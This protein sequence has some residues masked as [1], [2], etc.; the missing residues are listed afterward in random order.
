[1]REAALEHPGVEVTV[2]G[3]IDGRHQGRERLDPP[4]AGGDPQF[5]GGQRSFR[6]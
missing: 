3:G 1:M 2:T 4:D 6:V 5:F